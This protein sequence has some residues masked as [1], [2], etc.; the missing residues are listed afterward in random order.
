MHSN[1]KKHVIA[2]NLQYSKC[3]CICE[4]LISAN[5]LNFSLENYLAYWLAFLLSVITFANSWDPDQ[6][7]HS[8]QTFCW[9]LSGSKLFETLIVLVF[10]KV[11]IEKVNFGKSQ[12][13]TTKA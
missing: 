5:S 8:G 1:S 3:T 9:S 13:M 6:D 10:L 4:I 7:R 12:Q 11:F 2:K